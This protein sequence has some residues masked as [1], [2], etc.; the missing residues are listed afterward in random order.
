MSFALTIRPE[1]ETDLAEACRWY[2]ERRHDLGSESPISVEA[3]LESIQRHPQ[4]FPVVHSQIRR[5]LLRR[6]PYGVFY[7]VEEH[8]V[9]VLA[10]FHAS[11]D[12]NRWQNRA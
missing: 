3:T 2:E 8:A 6:F 10:V 12:P 7:V 4:S 5:A 9:A 11:R 1:A